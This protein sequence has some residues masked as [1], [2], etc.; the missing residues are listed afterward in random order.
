MTER[1]IR[2]TTLPE[3]GESG[4][5]KLQQARILLVG[6]G[7]LGSPIALYLTA[8][9]IGTL[10]LIDDDTVNISN[11]QRQILYTEDEIGLPKVECAAR[12]LKALHSKLQVN[13]YPY[14]LT[15]DNVESLVSSY[16]IV[17]D[18]CD[19]FDTRYLLNDACLLLGKPFVYGAIQEF[20]GQVSV[21][22]YG[23]HPRSYRELYPDESAMKQLTPVKAVMGI[24]PAVTG[25][26]QANEVLKILAGYGDVLSGRLWT[27]NL[28]NLQN[29]ILDF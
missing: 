27:I 8:A 4:Q 21:F 17:V 16:D 2:Q 10:G 15:A 5:T 18:G 28:R 25:S 26:I 9:G 24:T 3:I 14:R 6:V 29:F 13:T 22:G 1:F 19:N 7:G 23:D 11:L 12:R 20:E